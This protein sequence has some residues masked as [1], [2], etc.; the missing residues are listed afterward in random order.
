VWRL[1]PNSGLSS[2]GLSTSNET[3]ASLYFVTRLVYFSAAHRDWEEAMHLLGEL[4]LAGGIIVL[5]WTAMTVLV[6]LRQPRSSERRRQQA[7]RPHK[8]SQR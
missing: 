7:A 5:F 4:A 8:N 1:D 6:L 3:R 2:D